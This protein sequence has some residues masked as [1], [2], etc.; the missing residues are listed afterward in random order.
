MLPGKLLII[1]SACGYPA[2]NA[3]STNRSE[4]PALRIRL[5]LRAAVR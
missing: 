3:I 1:P 5:R 2:A 4:S